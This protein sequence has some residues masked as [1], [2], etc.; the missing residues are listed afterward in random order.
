MHLP[1]WMILDCQTSV[2]VSHSTHRWPCQ[3]LI[4]TC[5]PAVAALVR[6][7][8]ALLWKGG[9]FFLKTVRRPQMWKDHRTS[10]EALPRKWVFVLLM[11]FG[12]TLGSWVGKV[13]QRALFVV[14]VCLYGLC[15]RRPVRPPHFLYSYDLTMSDFVCHAASEYIYIYIYVHTYIYQ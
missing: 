11:F 5:S 10:F 6:R 12:L 3:L 4:A 14:S 8:P 7:C 9:V 1:W 2:L 13:Q 15:E